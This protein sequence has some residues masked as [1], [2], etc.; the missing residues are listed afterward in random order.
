MGKEKRHTC[1]GEIEHNFCLC[2]AGRTP[3]AES[4]I[5][6]HRVLTSGKNGRHIGIAVLISAQIHRIIA[7]GI[8]L[9]C[10]LFCVVVAL[11]EACAFIG[12]VR[13]EGKMPRCMPRKELI[14]IF[15]RISG[16]NSFKAPDS[17]R[18]R[19]AVLDSNRLLR[20]GCIRSGKIPAGLNR[21]YIISSVTQKFQMPPLRIIQIRG[22]YNG[23][24]TRYGNV[25]N[26][27]TLF[28]IRV[29]YNNI[30][31]LERH[32]TYYYSFIYR[33]PCSCRLT[34]YHI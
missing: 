2:R 19:L 13:I 9:P 28:R 10:R 24:R 4:G 21:R 26:V 27:K 16:I 12:R 25:L 14:P 30:T 32:N 1:G 22:I 31:G 7:H 18:G 34:R 11:D 20:H 17:L 6:F 29:L 23:S 5:C 3:A 33:Y 8:D 15:I